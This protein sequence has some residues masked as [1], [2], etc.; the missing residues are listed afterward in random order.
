MLKFCLVHG[1]IPLLGCLFC[2]LLV[3]ESA[4][5]VAQDAGQCLFCLP[6]LSEHL[7]LVQNNPGT[8]R[9]KPQYS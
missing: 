3:G 7:L 9:N 2:C 1:G 5:L 4:T 8:S 6:R